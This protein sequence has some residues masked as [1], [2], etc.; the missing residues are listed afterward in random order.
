MIGPKLPSV[1]ILLVNVDVYYCQ[2]HNFMKPPVKVASFSR[3]GYFTYEAVKQTTDERFWSSTCV[4]IGGDPIPVQTLLISWR[5][6]PRTI[7]NWSHRY[8]RWNLV[9]L[10]EER[11]RCFYPKQTWLNL[12]YLILR[13]VHQL[14]SL[15]VSA[16][17]PHCL[18]LIILAPSDL[19]MRKF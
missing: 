9:V 11:S 12:L 2:R 18:V 13:G 14:L 4:G 6:V 10:A 1:I 15:L 5:I 19:L 16:C 3:S 7:P 17:V 8:D